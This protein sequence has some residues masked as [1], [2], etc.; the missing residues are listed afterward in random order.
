MYA[1]KNK[2]LMCSF[3]TEFRDQSGIGVI[4]VAGEVD[5]AAVEL[6]RE[7]IGE[8]VL[9]RPQPPLVIVDVSELRFIDSAGIGPLV[10]ACQLTRERGGRLALTGLHGA[11]LKTF[12]VM[13]LDTAFLTYPTLDAAEQGLLRNPQPADSAFQ[14][15]GQG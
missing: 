14:V 2:K 13:G 8:V 11:P 15:R 3:R 9:E 12:Q 10:V 4:T 5:G 1:V 7:S 6:L